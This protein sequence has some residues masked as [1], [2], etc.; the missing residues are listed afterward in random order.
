MTTQLKDWQGRNIDP[1]AQAD[2]NVQQIL[3]S[4]THIAS[5]NGIPIYAPNGGG[6]GGGGSVSE[7]IE[8]VCGK[9]GIRAT[10]ASMSDGEYIALENYP[11][12]NTYGECYNFRAKITSFSKIKIG[13]GTN[14]VNNAFAGTYRCWLEIDST[15]INIYRNSSSLIGTIAHGL[16]ISTFISVNMRY[17]EDKKMEVT[18]MTIGGLV[19]KTINPY[20]DASSPFWYS[21][22]TGMVKAVSDGSTLTDCKLSATNTHYHSPLWI[23]GASYEQVEGWQSQVRKM[24]YTNYLINAYPGRNSSICYDDFVR[25]TA[26]GFPKFLY[27]TMWGNGSASDLDTYI[28]QVKALCDAQGTTLIIIDRPNSSATDVQD[29]YAARKA[30]IEKY[31]ALGVRFVDSASALSSNPSASDGWYS[32]YLSS[33]GKHPTSLGYKSLAMQVLQDLPEIM[34]Y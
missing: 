8:S 19:S 16:T 22:A 25:A 4:G 20:T 23:F 28:G 26:F 1:N 7:Y 18:I 14:T 3:T 9:A 27:W 24:G 29:T 2:V 10:K 12:A 34:Q 13:R 32:G 11:Y 5:I 33:D 17:T 15:N 31:K 6:G 30:A 21:D